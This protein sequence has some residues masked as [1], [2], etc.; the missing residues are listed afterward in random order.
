M[1]D[2]ALWF[3]SCI[4]AVS[5]GGLGGDLLVTHPAGNAQAHGVQRDFLCFLQ[6][7]RKQK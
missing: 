4:Q 7:G 2:E 5:G 6:R 3:S 1:I